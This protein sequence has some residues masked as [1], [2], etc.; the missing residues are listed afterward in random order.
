MQLRTIWYFRWNVNKSESDLATEMNFH[1][2]SMNKGDFRDG[3]GTGMFECEYFPGESSEF[4]AFNMQFGFGRE[5]R[6]ELISSK[7][8]NIAGL[9]PTQPP[10]HPPALPAELPLDIGFPGQFLRKSH[11]PALFFSTDN[12]YFTP[13]LPR[14]TLSCPRRLGSLS[15]KEDRPPL[16]EESFDGDA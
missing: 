16:T 10:P 12:E 13:R 4:A 14:F 7:A 15:G 2:T 8:S 5:S 11:F 9:P 6:R 3:V 1:L